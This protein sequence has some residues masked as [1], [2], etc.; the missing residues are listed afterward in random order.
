MFITSR[1]LDRRAP[2]NATSGHDCASGPQASVCA[3]EHMEATWRRRGET[4][5]GSSGNC[6]HTLSQGDARST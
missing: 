5:G 6:W 3:A 4:T 1:R 2:R